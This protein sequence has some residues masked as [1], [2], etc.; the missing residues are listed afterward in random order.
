[1]DTVS[2]VIDKKATIVFEQ[3]TE[4]AML[5]IHAT[6]ASLKKPRTWTEGQAKSKRTTGIKGKSVSLISTLSHWQ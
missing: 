6:L 3:L 5:P 4:R 1:M 2:I